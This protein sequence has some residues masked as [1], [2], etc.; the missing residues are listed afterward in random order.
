MKCEGLPIATDVCNDYC[1]A[2]HNQRPQIVPN[3]QNITHVHPDRDRVSSLEEA[4][5]DAIDENKRLRAKIADMTSEFQWQIDEIN[6]MY[7]LHVG[8]LKDELKKNSES[9][10]HVK[11]DG[12]STQQNVDLLKQVEAMAVQIQKVDES[13][14]K[15][16]LE[17]PKPKIWEKGTHAQPVKHS[18]ADC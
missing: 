7:N 16:V 11:S 9:I 8:K 4:L 15:K 6:G 1:R 10:S 13:L 14:K 12:V 18:K 2:C 17:K 3:Q 5:A